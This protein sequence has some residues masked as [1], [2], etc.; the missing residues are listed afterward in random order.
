LRTDGT[1]IGLNGRIATLRAGG[2]ERREHD[3]R[4]YAD[5]ADN[6]EKFDERKTFR[7]ILVHKL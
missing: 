5:D 3:C 7:M 6:D 4:E 1:K 2:V